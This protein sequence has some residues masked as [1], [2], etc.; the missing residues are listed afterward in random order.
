MIES[1]ETTI[2]DTTYRVTQLGAKQG[3]RLLMRLLRL[4]GPS[5]TEAIGGD[6]S[7]ASLGDVD[8]STL[9]G[10]VKRLCENALEDELEHLFDT[11]APKTQIDKGEG[12][13]A[14]LSHEAELHFAGKYREMFEWLWFCLQVNYKDFIVGSMA[15]AAAMT[16][17]ATKSESLTA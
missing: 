10:A 16:Q 14:V 3:R 15:R 8:L 11:F 5:L 4:A 9:S 1:E 6:T 2:G 17:K 13:W 12:K 7:L